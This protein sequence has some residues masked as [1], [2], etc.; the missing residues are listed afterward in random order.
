MT[1]KELSLYGSIAVVFLASGGYLLLET[2]IRP[3]PQVG[4]D[5]SG[6][7]TIAYGFHL[8]TWMLWG[9]V[10]NY[11]WDRFS[12][13]RGSDD[14]QLPKILLPMCISPIVF[15]AIWSLWPGKEITFALCLVAFQ[16]GF[17]WQVVLNKAGP[18]G[19]PGST[20]V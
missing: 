5:V 17:F 16:N 13:G 11:W 3:K 10:A 6:L 7:L 15:F 2:Q 12:S 1:G 20:R 18:V 8:M 19:S 14:M 9:M 4:P